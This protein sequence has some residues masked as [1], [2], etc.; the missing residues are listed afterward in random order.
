MAAKSILEA[1]GKQILNY[2]LTRAFCHQAKLPC[3]P[4]RH[5]T[6]LLLKLVS[7]NFP[8]DVAVGSSKAHISRF[9]ANTDQLIKRRGKKWTFWHLNP[10][11]DW[12]LAL[13]KLVTV[14]A[15]LR[16]FLVEPIFVPHPPE[17]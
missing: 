1:D 16:Q 14:E 4:N 3:P 13:V 6:I 15:V 12:R 11:L 9:V 5:P 8:E 7:L 10:G 2:H 17:T